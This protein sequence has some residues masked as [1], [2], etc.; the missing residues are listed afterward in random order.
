MAKYE[1]KQKVVTEEPD[2]TRVKNV[3]SGNGYC[4]AVGNELLLTGALLENIYEM[5]VESRM[6]YGV[7]IWRIYEA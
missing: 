5:S 1:I 7:E 4:S 6:L 3:V 2:E